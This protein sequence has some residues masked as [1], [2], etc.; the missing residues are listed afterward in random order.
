LK[1]Y[2]SFPSPS[3]AEATEGRP[4]VLS[5]GERRFIEKIS[6]KKVFSTAP[7]RPFF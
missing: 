6:L 3:F 4:L 1:K 2:L 5:G 7:Q